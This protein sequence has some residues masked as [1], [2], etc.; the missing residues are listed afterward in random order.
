MAE[1][2][3]FVIVGGKVFGFDNTEMTSN[4]CIGGTS[5]LRLANRLAF[6]PSKPSLILLEAR[7]DNSGDINHR[8]PSKRWSLPFINPELDYGYA[9]TPQPGLKDLSLSRPIERKIRRL[10]RQRP[11][12]THSIERL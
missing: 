9:T 4:I 2:A 1:T 3:D 7:S 12:N 8:D 6:S 5:G 11:L 10:S